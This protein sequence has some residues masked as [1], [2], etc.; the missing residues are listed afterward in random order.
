MI[1]VLSRT[2]RSVDHVNSNSYG[3]GSGHVPWDED[4][5]RTG[6]ENQLIRLDPACSDPINDDGKAQDV[7]I[8]RLRTAFAEQSTRRMHVACCSSSS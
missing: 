3:I 2:T 6:L 5:S 7:L 1:H 8:A 4:V